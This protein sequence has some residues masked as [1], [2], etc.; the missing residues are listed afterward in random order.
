MK[1]GILQCDDVQEALQLEFGNYPCMF[2][3][4]LNQISNDLTWQ[5]Y[6]VRIGEYP[7]HL[8]DCDGYISTGSRY[9]VNDSLAWLEPLEA[10]V[11]KAYRAKKPFVGI[12]FGHQL[13]AKALG[14]KVDRSEKGWGAGISF[15]QIVVQTP[16]M[17]PQQNG[18]D[19]VVSHQD[20]VVELPENAQVLAQSS[21][22]L[23]YMIQ[24]GSSMLGIQGHPEFSR[25]Y[26]SALTNARRDRIP[27]HRVREALNSL[28]ADVDDLTMAR[29]ILN[30]LQQ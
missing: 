25:A 21:F 22:C 24:I 17:K 4:L 29:W 28:H 13:I 7:E 11:Q 1:I 27:A 9:G 19:L 30:F 16:W 20:Q 15:N 14:G 6:D 2:Q 3:N 5:V 12:C 23:N 10:F 26:S 8:D 18:L